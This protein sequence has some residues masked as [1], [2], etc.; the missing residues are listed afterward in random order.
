MDI[1]KEL[2]KLARNSVRLHIQG[3]ADGKCGHTRFGGIPDVPADFI[4]PVFKTNT[5]E[6]DEVRLRPLSFLA[7]IN[8]EEMVQFDQEHL[9]P[10]NGVLSFFYETGSQRWGFDPKDNGCARV[11]WF[12]DADRLQ[13]AAIPDT[14]DMAYRFPSIRMTAVSEPSCPDWA[15][16][17]LQFESLRGQLSLFFAERKAMGIEEPGNCSKLL[18]WPDTIQGNM[19]TECELVA[20]GYYLGNTWKDIPNQDI[21]DAKQNSLKDWQLLF[22]LDTVTHDNFELM[23]GDCGRIYFFIRKKDLLARNFDRIWLI[24][25]CG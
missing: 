14:L 11:F 10:Q 4:W 9:L 3:E 7:Q 13:P 22:Q 21:Q 2:E 18:G 24:L 16:F 8:C 1:Q 23:F 6:D 15:D 20:R 19:T 5:Y 12:E 17:S 25:Q